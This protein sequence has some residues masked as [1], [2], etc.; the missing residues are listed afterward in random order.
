M[1]GSS[2]FF[3]ENKM[4]YE[5]LQ[6]ASN[7]FQSSSI[8]TP[9]V[10]SG[11]VGEFLEK[12]SASQSRC[13]RLVH[14]TSGRDWKR[15]CQIAL[16]KVPTRSY[17]HATHDGN[18]MTFRHIPSSLLLN[19]AAQQWAN[20]FLW[21]GDTL[22]SGRGSPVSCLPL[23]S[24]HSHPCFVKAL[25]LRGRVTHFWQANQLVTALL[26]AQVQSVK[27]QSKQKHISKFMVFM[28]VYGRTLRNT[29]LN[30]LQHLYHLYNQ[31]IFI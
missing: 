28:A 21:P 26:P 6:W 27:F 30:N 4:E 29:K 17:C 24:G 10:Q 14:N 25:P 13:R 2:V 16:L 12:L 23:N 15:Q 1:T 19:G 3:L 18:T 20:I 31:V 5:S 8:Q 22:V 9:F 7:P 11:L